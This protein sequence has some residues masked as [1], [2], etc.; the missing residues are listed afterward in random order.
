MA[1]FDRYLLSQ[2]MVLFGFFS[3]VLVMVYWVNRAVGLFDQ[4]IADGQSA[5]VFLELSALTLPN[6]I[7]IVLPISAFIATVYTTN[8]LAAESELV[9][10]Q[11]T[12]FSPFRLARPVIYFGVV[13]ALFMSILTH[14][15]VP[16]SSRI[17]AERQ[18]DISQNITARF[19][20][21]GDFLHPS[22]GITFYIRQ[23]RPSGEMLDIFL[24]DQREEVLPTIY[25]ANRA[26]LVRDDDGGSK[27][28]MF[29]GL[30]QT[31]DPQAETLAATRF[32][33]FAYD[34]SALIQEEDEFTI[35]P[36]IIPTA[37]LLRLDEEALALSGATPAAF[38]SEAHDR[39]AQPLLSIVTSL[40]GFACLLLGGF[41]RFGVWRQIILA[42]VL[43]AA[44]KSLDNKLADVTQTQAELWPLLY[45]PTVVGIA[46]AALILWIAQTPSLFRR[47]RRYGGAA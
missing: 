41:S 10:V 39:I 11:T 43:L 20:S 21:E 2:L 8:R 18:N 34:I 23:I 15:L 17:L 28:L 33:D 25:T 9:V 1:K 42:V 36:R 22:D 44:I 12:G 30:A 40:I 16:L 27:L 46:V 5:L 4:L 24:S 13:V 35:W 37:T 7:R 14:F 32:E 26:L 45:L 6:V 19:L 29:D 3:L 31:L 47:Q 38:L